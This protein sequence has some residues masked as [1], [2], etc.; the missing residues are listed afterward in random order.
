MKQHVLGL[1][2][3]G[4]GPTDHRFLPPLLERL[5]TNVLLAEGRYPVRIDPPVHLRPASERSRE[6]GLVEAVAETEGAVDVL[7]LH[8]DG[9]GDPDGTR[10]NVLAP[11]V[12]AVEGAFG[13]G[14]PLFVPVVPVREMEAWMIADP[15]TLAQVVG[16]TLDAAGLGLP[17]R[18]RDVEGVADPKL[19]LEEAVRR[20]RSRTRRRR[21]QIPYEP[22]GERIALDRLRSVAAFAR[23]E[24]D[25]TERLSERWMLEGD[26]ADG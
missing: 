18:A 15:A 4:E 9:N 2:F 24:A 12:D 21:V 23:L 13:D 14:A 3:H 16:S 20:A 1:G 7:F 8:A 26:G 17:A 6:E 11:L 10:D 25:L 22:I 19:A 5:T